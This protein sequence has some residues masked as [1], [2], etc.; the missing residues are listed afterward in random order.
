[1]DSKLDLLKGAISP[2]V[3][4][5]VELSN[6][7]TFIGEAMDD[8]TKIN[9]LINARQKPE[10]TILV[11]FAGY[12]KTSFVAS[13]YHVLLTKGKIGDY[14]FYDS[15][16]LTGLERRLYLR[17]ASEKYPEI[18]PATKRTLRGE[19][20]LLTFRFTHPNKGEKVVVLSDHSGEDYQA[21]IDT[22]SKLE[23]DVLLKNADRMLFFVDCEAL[24]SKN[25]LS[26]VQKYTQL[27]RN[28]KEYACFR[29]DVKIQ[30]LFNKFDL[31]EGK[32]DLY[33]QRKVF[34]LGKM[35]EI[36]GVKP[37]DNPEI[38]SNQLAG[39]DT[40][41]DLLLDIVDKTVVFGKRASCTDSEL[42]WVKKILK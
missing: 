21:Y 12:G 42:D 13:C 20:H 22:K 28:M 30:F 31:V 10:I 2:T 8:D 38:V 25:V 11:G 14:T 26:V 33:K 3:Q 37:I 19:P 15:D 29:T 7:G 24:V 16:T 40:I 1:M 9:C 34:F 5:P 18:I 17:R 35:A 41:I 4:A 32:E 36:L 27:I 23:N 39:N 6:I